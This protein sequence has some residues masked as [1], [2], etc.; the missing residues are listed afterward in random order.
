MPVIRPSGANCD[1]IVDTA[2]RTLSG[3]TLVFALDGNLELLDPAGQ[4]L[5]E[6]GTSGKFA[7]LLSMQTDGNLVIYE[8]SRRRAIWSTDT[9]GNP[10]AFLSVQEDGNVVIYT[11]SGTPIWATGTNSPS[12]PEINVA[13]GRGAT[14]VRLRPAGKAK[15]RN[16]ASPSKSYPSELEM[17]EQPAKPKAPRNT[18]RARPRPP[19]EPSLF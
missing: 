7:R 18:T 8:T 12:Q 4:L 2:W 19:T 9:A 11:S 15:T 10:G 5:W 13:A 14:V 1:F 16:K 3:Y 17:R 6:S